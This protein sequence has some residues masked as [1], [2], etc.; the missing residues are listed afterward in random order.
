MDE[1]FASQFVSAPMGKIFRG[2]RN[3]IAVVGVLDDI[4]DVDSG[5]A[6]LFDALSGTE[7]AKLIPSD[8]TVDDW[9]SFSL[10]IDDSI[11]V[12]GARNTDG[13]VIRSE[14][15]Y[16]FEAFTGL[17][18][19]KLFADDGAQ[20]DSFGHSVAIENGLIAVGATGDDDNGDHSGSV[21]LFSAITGVQIAKLQPSDGRVS[22]VFGSS[23]AIDNG[24]IAIGAS[25]DGDNG[26]NA[27][28]AYLFNAST[29]AQ[30][31]KLLPNDGEAQDMFGNSIDIDNGIV[32]IGAAG[33]DDT[34]FAAGS[35]YLFN[36]STGTQIAKLYA[37]DGDSA[38][39]FGNSVSIVRGVAAI[40]VRWRD[41]DNGE[42]YGSAYLFDAFNGV[43]IVKLLPSDGAE[44][45]Q[46]GRAIA[47]DNG[48]VAVG[49]WHDDDLGIDSG[50]AY[51]F[52]VSCHIVDIS[53]DGEVNVTDL[54]NLLAN[55]GAC[56][57]PCPQD[58]T[59]DGNVNVTDLL[60]LFSK[61][62]P[63]P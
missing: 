11:V 24:I 3:V 20:Y 49:A 12:V 61:W 33:D 6:F 40:G 46:F 63:C 7:L 25:Q 41:G 45:E 42:A 15:V 38:D 28:A 55:W 57:G 44:G 14:S 52:D 17:Q 60:K 50:S 16:L 18:I 48:M 10:A 54:L 62:G 19:A 9:F 58:I 51:V 29:G 39:L 26:P 23:I 31:F 13:I 53:R 34:G 27:G 56:P 37:S 32:V 35:A 1:A 4:D 21:Y 5:S 8:G 47:I 2:R 59:A 22:Q 36:A 43:Q 30:M